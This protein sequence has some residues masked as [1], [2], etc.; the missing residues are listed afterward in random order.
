MDYRKW[1]EQKMKWK[2]R[3]KWEKILAWILCV[4][5]LVQGVPVYAAD[6]EVMPH[7]VSDL[8][9]NEVQEKT[10]DSKSINETEVENEEKTK[11]EPQEFQPEEEIDSKP[12]E[13]QIGEG[14]MQDAQEE[15]VQEVTDYSKIYQNGIIKI[16]NKSQLYAVGSGQLV[17]INDDREDIYGTGEEVTE[18]GTTITYSM[19]AKYQLMNDIELDEKNLWLLPEGFRGS[20]LSESVTEEDPLYN[21]E[22]DAVYVYHNYQLLTVASEESET[23][24]IM[25]KD[26]IASD[27]GM[28]QFLY[29]NGKPA[30]ETVEAAQDYLTYSK[31]HHYMLSKKFTE[32]MPELKAEQY[33]QGTT[34]EEQKAGRQHVGQV[35]T[36]ID[37]KKYILIGNE[38]QLRKIG[39]DTQV[40]PMLFLR[41]EARLLLVPLG[42][43]IVPYY[44]GDADFNLRDIRETDVSYQDIKEQTEGFQYFGQKPEKCKDLMNVDWGDPKGLLSAVVG[45]VG[46]LLG[47]ILGELL[48]K[49]EIVGLKD[50]NTDHPSIG[51][52]R[53]EY[54]TFFQLEKQYKDLTYSSDS[55]YIVFRDINLSSGE[56]SNGEEDIWNP[57]NLSGNMEGRKEMVDGQPVTISNVNVQQVGKLDPST[58]RGVGFFGSISSQIDD[59]E[60]GHSK[61]TTVVK[62]IHLQNVTVNNQSTEVKLVNLS[63]V[64]ILLGT[65]GGILGG[66]LGLVGGI[67]DTLLGWAI[68]GLERIGSLSDVLIG[69]LTINSNRSDIFATGS[70]VG[71]IVGDVKIQNC[72]VEQAAVSN[73]K[74]MTG[75]FA[76]YTEGTE[77]YDGLS[78]LLGGTVSLLAKIL[79]IIPGIGIGDL[80][81][82]LL[83]NN[84]INVGQLFPVGYYKPVLE[85]CSVHLA[86]SVIGSDTTNYTGGFVGIQIATK[87][88]GC[89]VTN[90]Q[91]VKAK[92]GAGGFAGIERDA[93]INSLLSNLGVQLVS[94]DIQSRQDNCIVIGHSLNVS[95]TDLYAG[96]FNG[97]MTNSVSTGCKV[98]NISKVSAGKYA[99]G[100]T[101]R[102]TIGAGIVLGNEDERKH[103]LLGS[104]TEL[105]TQ[106]VAPGNED[107]LNTLLALSGLTPSELH[108][109]EVQG[110][111]WTVT[112]KENYAGG[113]LGQGDGA[114][115]SLIQSKGAG[116]Q[117]ILDTKP[118]ILNGLASVQARNYA[119]GLGGSIVTANPIGIL[120]QT[121]GVG[122]YL[123]FYAGNIQL[124]GSNLKVTAEEKYASAGFGLMLG[125]R[126][127]NV[128]IRNV[129]AVI[130]QN[131]V[132]GLAGRAGAGSLAQTGGIDVLGLGLIKVNN[133]LSLAQG[134]NVKAKDIQIWGIESGAIISATGTPWNTTSKEEIFA[135]GLVS[136]ADGIQVKNANVSNIKEI[137]AEKNSGETS[138][139]GGFTGKSHTGG[140]AG[141]A[142]KEADGKLK[143]SGILDVSNLLT[144]VPYLLPEYEN[145][146]VEFVSN[147]E[148]PQVLAD[149]AGG[150]FGQMDSGKVTNPEQEPYA[151]YG[152][153]KVKATE[154]AG[155]FAGKIK[156]GA[157]ASSNGLKLLGGILNL[158]LNNLLSVLNVYIPVIESAGIKSADG[159][160]TV[161]AT[162]NES[163][164]GGYAGI[165]SGATIRKSNVDSLKHTKV[166]ES[167]YFNASCYAVKAGRYAGGYVGRADIDSAAQVGGGLKL[168]NL[169]DLNNLLSAMKVVATKIEDCNVSGMVGGFSVLANGKG[170]IGKAGGFAGEG[171]GCQITNSNVYNFL[172]II[173]QEMAGGYAGHL[174]PGNAVAVLGEK[175]D[176]LN[177]LINVNDTL[178]SL[179]N[180]FVP[181]IKNSETTAVPC[182][183]TV[184]A[185]GTTDTAHVRGLA[186]GYVGY[187]H[188]ATIKGN[189]SKTSGRKECA[190][191]RLRSVYGTE[192]AGGFT[193]FM[194]NADLV[195]TGNLN[196]LFGLVS[197]NNVLG[198]LNAVY[199]T[200][201]NTAVYGP[202]RKLDV[203]TWNKWADAVAA[204]GAYGAQFPADKVEDQTALEAMIPKYAYGYDVTAGRKE[205]GNLAKQLGDAGGYVG[206]MQGG[207][208]TEAH[209]WDTKTVTA[210][211]SA[212]GFAGEMMTGGVAEIGNVS[213]ANGA[214]DI[215][216]SIN[217]VQTFVPVIRNSDISGF[218][219]GLNVISHGIPQQGDRIEKVGYAGGYVGHVVG[220]QI[221]GNWNTPSNTP[222]TF[223]ITDAVEKEENNRCFVDNL[224]QVNGTASVGGFVGLVEPG[225]AASLDT[226]GKGG[227]L[228]G[229]LQNLI[230]EP[231]DLVQLLNAT[232]STIEAADVKAWDDYGITINGVYS[233]GT[234]NTKYAKSAGG[235]AGELQGTVIGKLNHPEQG[236]TV[237]NL[238]SVT[239]GKHAGGFFGYADVSS[240]AEISNSD[241]A[242]NSTSII[243]KL[244]GLDSIT[245]LDSFRTFIY[246]S[247]VFGTKAAGLSVDAKEGNSYGYPN[248]PFFTGNAGGFGGSLCN[249]SVKGS[250]VENLREVEGRNYVGGFIGHLDKGGVLQ[251]D[252]I[253]LLGKFLS[254]GADILSAFG[255]HVDN[256]KVSGI[257]E[258][259]TVKSENS[260]EDENKDEIAGGFAGYADLARMKNN[261]VENIKQVSSGQTA[262]GF[263][264]K[265]SFKYLAEIK[266]DS[267][268][269]N[270]LVELLK[271]LLKAIWLEDIQSGPG[272]E[273]NLGIIKVHVVSKEDGLLHVNLLGLDIGIELVKT[274]S[275]NG[276]AKIHIGDSVIEINCAED[277]SVKMDDQHLKD[278][279]H[280]S[281]I[282]ANRTRIERC[283]ITGIKEGYD[284]Y[285]GGAGNDKNGVGEKGCAGGFAGYNNEGL[286]KKNEMYL[287]DVIRGTK[288]ITGPFSGKTN[289]NTNT[290]EFINS[291]FKIEGEDNHYRIYRDLQNITNAENYNKVMKGSKEL[292]NGFTHTPEWNIYEFHHRAKN[293]V[294]KVSDL[295]GAVLEGPDNEEVPL[296]AYMEQGAKVVLMNDV[297]TKPTE[298][299]ETAPPA[300]VQDPCKDMVQLRIRKVWK[301]DKEANRPEK[302]LLHF[303]RSYVD[304]QGN[305]I[306]DSAF[307]SANHTVELTKKDYQS[308]N[309]WEKIIT[310]LPFTAYYKDVDGT[311]RYYT[312]EVTEDALDGYQT[313]ITYQGKYH[314]DITITNRKK[315]TGF[316]PNTG[317]AGTF[318]IYTIA[319]LVFLSMAAMELNS[320]K[321][322]VYNK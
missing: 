315:F 82:L 211:K 266:V 120:N 2:R 243:G 123:P 297:G 196:I 321:K 216:G 199:P 129:D 37:G 187:N 307:N 191:V 189:D 233:D 245:A 96:G 186:G 262:G 302:I 298:P 155:G 198:L 171:S 237:T 32:Q 86:S 289:L 133:V 20:F 170:D 35:Y 228:D 221:W 248:T 12:Q 36:E 91:S 218:Q 169:L 49:Q 249:G 258:G 154:C 167:D 235:F 208:I 131:Y 77:K 121:I 185:K 277:G 236:T 158:D 267:P 24:P 147:G 165:A 206:K 224:R 301:K 30:D 70:F 125:G 175:S 114:T 213:L 272:I 286:F 76:G 60:L 253:G 240:V 184:C 115:I 51:S 212:G 306:Q 255:S 41:T 62:N 54:K 320:R 316:L 10:N 65:I 19:E 219:S 148:N 108:Y 160:F 278:E 294:E 117:E 103:N 222:S 56:F 312:Y 176:I 193:G 210:Y 254:A 319:I 1:G 42:S 220:G 141:I 251:V 146:K 318:W 304:G 217:A 150:F 4:T 275:G 200:E 127:E 67:L 295:I 300:D 152:I 5:I 179:V 126:A 156:A 183:G 55:N 203:D 214:L 287:A 130:A 317:G 29:K 180:A 132:G 204:N 270:K 7:I 119:G 98:Q 227:L 136:E 292:Q 197:V 93:V 6:L 33:A 284:V 100:F 39:T 232:M 296:N 71:R 172:Y 285:G 58:T 21:S 15:S 274:Q 23:E 64:K 17:H 53:N 106:L 250:S 188:G 110:E 269:V 14:E 122:S 308:K 166:D 226:A 238:R 273:V 282:K 137:K 322:Q 113:L 50:E 271:Q 181:I 157:A 161:E 291:V 47:E 97:I 66:V 263:V 177:G 105:L 281:L 182:G 305:T 61:G 59:K 75:G 118:T 257:P 99:G 283:T 101:G 116:D 38:Q 85:N 178:A 190:V 83:Q 90:L 207:V 95:A 194:E 94:F 205:A 215:L 225:G 78:Q 241:G 68:P 22:L 239:G 44:P 223:H 88:S 34:T 145:C 111:N 74:D 151:V 280:I 8:H 265:T 16:Y 209:A 192:A 231:K 244:I 31:K 230:K 195:G 143:L 48:G 109:C 242:G 43:K 40:T 173:G 89:V 128:I 246:D 252:N 124:I 46:N 159:G 162:N 202:L 142:Q 79:N 57:I 288:D 261:Q 313:T 259:F 63:L 279:I 107:K 3:K 293:K 104:V 112:A 84:I 260:A 72:V 256:S 149:Y 81:T 9:S 290:P 153:V 310:G 102:A 276:L 25:S 27:F 18:N 13:P 80:I 299:D 92:T 26:M 28:G 247:K 164:A 163:S 139:A 11:L 168:L 138:Y 69:L 174:E 303:T 73:V 87:M 135:G 134:V 201:T 311:K 268:L 234:A 45:I 52:K 140:L 264:G 314:Y 144:L 309:V 229:L